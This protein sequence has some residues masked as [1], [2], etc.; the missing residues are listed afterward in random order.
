MLI[1]RPVAKADLEGL[2][3][4]AALTGFGLTTLPR[5]RDLLAERIEDSEQSFRRMAHRPRG[6]CY[7]FVMED[8]A[9]RHR[10]IGTCGMHLQS[11]RL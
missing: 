6:E 3:D 10:V 11:R 8:P 1:I 7:L 2:H 5:D 9:A 4:L